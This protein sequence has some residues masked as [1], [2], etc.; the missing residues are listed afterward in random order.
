MQKTLFLNG[1]QIASYSGLTSGGNANGTQVTLSGVTPLGS[2][3]E[4]F[5]VVVRQTGGTDGFRNGQQVDVYDADET[6]LYS[7]LNPQNDQFQGRASSS[8]HQIFTAEPLVISVGGL[9]PDESGAVR[10][11]PGRHPA[12][13]ETLSFDR[14]PTVV[15]CFVAGTRIAT[16]EG[17][18]A[19][20]TLRPGDPVLTRDHGARPI[21]W[22]GRRTV[23]GR[24][25]LAPVEIAAG[26]L[27]ARRPLFVSPQ[28]RLLVRSGLAELLFGA[29]E[30]LVPAAALMGG[31]GVR[32]RPM[33]QV[34]YLHVLLD[35]HELLEAEGCATESLLP[36]SRLT[37][38]FD[39]LAAAL[40]AI[41]PATPA[42]PLLGMAEARLLRR[43]KHVPTGS[44][45]AA[46]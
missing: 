33:P 4:W 30:V 3:D 25:V 18:R 44:P 38:G 10:F 32:R 13:N 20:E 41:G 19:V 28:H 27:G 5:R 11:G 23:A 16:P 34:T 36:G 7:G 14:F 37:S 2:A 45:A 39:G 22:I 26:C 9:E 24:G 40:A 12:R 17:E 1:S 21:R 43:A 29:A 15:P 31:A 46:A 35:R 42:R 6:L 8:G